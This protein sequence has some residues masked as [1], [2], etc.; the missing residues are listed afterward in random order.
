MDQSVGGRVVRNDLRTA[1][2]PGQNMRSQLFAQFHAH[3]I[4]GINV[5]ND[6]LDE[7]FM[8]VKGESGT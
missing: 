3:L 2:Q 7:N 1:T 5:P 6:T 4:K 8:F